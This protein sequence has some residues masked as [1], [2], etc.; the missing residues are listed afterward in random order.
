LRISSQAAAVTPSLPFEAR[1]AACVL[2]VWCL[3]PSV[4]PAST[5][6][7]LL[8]RSRPYILQTHTQTNSQTHTHSL[9]LSHTHTLTN[10]KV[11]S[12]HKGK[13]EGEGEEA[14]KGNKGGKSKSKTEEVVEGDA[15]YVAT[16]CHLTVLHDEDERIAARLHP[17]HGSIS[18]YHLKICMIYIYIYKYI[19]NIL[20]VCMLWNK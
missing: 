7:P 11:L 5:S 4:P 12:R 10:T 1:T 14:E 13:G 15:L 9:S 16:A 8:K 19:Y 3:P 20:H 6:P 2:L 18:M 17:Q